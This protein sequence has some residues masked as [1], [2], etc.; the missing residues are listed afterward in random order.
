MADP[1]RFT[2][3]STP[4]IVS[5]PHDSTH[6]PDEIARRMT[7]AALATP[8]TDW[9]VAKL[10]DFA[11][12]LGATMLT[13][14]HS[15][16]VVDLNRDPSG[17]ALYPGADNTEV[18]PLRTFDQESIY[19]AGQEPDAA[20][21]AARIATFWR[22][23]HAKLAEA[24]AATHRRHGVAVI[25]DGHTIRSRVAR[26]FAGQ[27]SD[28]NL[29]TAKGASVAPELGARVFA[30]LEGSG[31][32]AVRDERFTGG[33][34]TRTYGRPAEGVNVLQLELTWRTYMDEG[35][36]FAYLP[37][38]AARLK[39]VLRAMVECGLAWGTTQRR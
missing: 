13:A 25:F 9:H 29:G 14:T 19:R 8:D 37:D 17:E 33:Y 12:G 1:Y 18:C 5:L 23:Y 26:F 35:P 22:P 31:Y 20:E 28:L 34:I 6:I 24:I 3:G 10:Y 11:A 38:R 4:L 21:I 27:L 16:Y 39:T 32:S 15:R 2:A 30:I 7:P 36:P